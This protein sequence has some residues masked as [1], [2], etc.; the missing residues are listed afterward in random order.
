MAHYDPQKKKLIGGE[1]GFD[2]TYLNMERMRSY[3]HEKKFQNLYP[4]IVC[5]CTHIASGYC[6]D[7]ENLVKSDI[8][9]IPEQVC[10]LAIWK[11][12]SILCLCENPYG[13]KC[14]WKS[15][16]LQKFFNPKT[17]ES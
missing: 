4:T 3:L 10:A 15:D 9:H 2:L 7:L 6:Y 12:K 11:S 14:E 8:Y 17:L 16:K 5:F 13:V 1:E